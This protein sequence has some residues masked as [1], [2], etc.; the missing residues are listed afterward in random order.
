M[1][2]IPHHKLRI[3]LCLCLWWKHTK[4][5]YCTHIH[6][7]N[8]CASTHYT[9][10]THNQTHNVATLCCCALIADRSGNHFRFDSIQRMVGT[11]RC[12]VGL[13]YRQNMYIH[14]YINL[15]LTNIIMNPKMLLLFTSLVWTVSFI[16]Q[17]ISLVR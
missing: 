3:R 5:V 2:S 17:M 1:D 10:H 8:I 7:P 13:N 12:T 6:T 16:Q 15:V 14:T 9:A 4:P 11:T